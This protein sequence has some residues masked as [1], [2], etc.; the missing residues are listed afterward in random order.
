MRYFFTSVLCAA[1]V[2]CAGL[3][4]GFGGC[5]KQEKTTIII[6]DGQFSEMRI[7]HHAVKLLVESNTRLT[8]D[9]RDEMSPVNS[10]NQLVKGESYLMNSYDGTVLATFLKLDPIDVPAG[11]TLYEFV[12]KIV[13]AK[14]KVRLLDKLGI[15][16]TYAIAAPAAVV[17]KYGLKTVSDLVPV[18]KELVFGAEHEFFSLEGSARFKPFSSF[19]GLTFKDTKPIDIGLKYYAIE[20]GNVEVTVT[21]ATDGMNRKAGLFILQDDR[22]FFP[23]YNGALLVRNALFEEVKETAPNLESVLNRLGGVF[24]DAIMSDLTYAV[25]VDELEPAAVAEAFLVE[26]GLLH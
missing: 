11:S 2:G 16:N 8:V 1:I 14:H 9:I 20:T 18:A 4:L 5:S 6:Q 12:N 10:F 26:K 21:Y 22:G 7:I 19:Y 3:C 15:N 24:T 13:S 23:E 25:D 17:D